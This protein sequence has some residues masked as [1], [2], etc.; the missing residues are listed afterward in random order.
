MSIFFFFSGLYGYNLT[1]SWQVSPPVS[2]KRGVCSSPLFF[3]LQKQTEQ[4]TRTRRNTHHNDQRNA[5]GYSKGC[6]L[7]RSLMPVL[8]RRGHDA[9]NTHSLVIVVQQTTASSSVS[10]TI[11]PM[12]LQSLTF[13]LHCL[14]KL[15]R[16]PSGFLV[17]FF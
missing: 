9:A 10:C 7:Q 8:P 4:R 11:V 2:R 15:L 5:G 14:F 17:Y 16:T 13:C 1:T 12:S 3:F 6:L